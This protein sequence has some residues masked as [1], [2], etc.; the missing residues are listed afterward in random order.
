MTQIELGNAI[1]FY[2]KWPTPIA[3]ISDG[4]YGLSSYPGD[5]KEPQR[6]ADWYEPHIEKWSKYSTPQT[7]LWFWNSELGWAEVHGVL[8]RYGWEYR[9]CHI[10]DKGM[11]HVAG[12]S[13]GSTLRKF[14]VTTEVCVQYTKRAIF[15][16]PTGPRSMKEWLRSEWLRSGLPLN[17]TNEACGVK[18]AATRKYFTQCHLWYYPPPEA[19]EMLASYANRHGRAE[20]RPYFSADGKR[21]LSREEW[22]GMRAKFNFKNGITNVWQVPAVRNGERV[23][24]RGGYVHMNQKPLILMVRCIEASTDLGDVVWE[25][26][27][28]LCSA[29]VAAGMTRR[30]GF[31]AEI[32]PKFF[33]AAARRLAD[34]DGQKTEKLFPERESDSEFGFGSESERAATTRQDTHPLLLETR[35]P[36]KS[37]H[38]CT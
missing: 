35:A 25:P 36:S 7:T 23:K 30:R 15:P 22:G 13:N 37:H 6:L 32:N 5:L 9:N 31:A 2:G 4:P 18:N 1:D 29:T 11:A 27:G 21:R 10:W 24:A 12:N 20:G 34:A 14:P 8:A 28:G 33:A 26:F 19:F 38:R 16:S 17:K 3:I